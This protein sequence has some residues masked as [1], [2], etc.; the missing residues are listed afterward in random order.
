MAGAVLEGAGMG[1][2][3]SVPLIIAAAL[4]DIPIYFLSQI[5]SA[6]PIGSLSEQIRIMLGNIFNNGGRQFLALLVA[7]VMVGLISLMRIPHV[8]VKIGP[9]D[10]CPCRS[11]KKY[12][13]CCMNR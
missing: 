4:I 11:G 8:N 10:S 13:H 12:K 6:F 2:L 5:D 9:N 1:A 7:L 3:I